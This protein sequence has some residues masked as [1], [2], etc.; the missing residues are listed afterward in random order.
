LYDNGSSDDCSVS[1][2]TTTI[3]M[4]SVKRMTLGPVGVALCVGVAV[5]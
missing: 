5:D 2:A 3:A 4:I 1:P